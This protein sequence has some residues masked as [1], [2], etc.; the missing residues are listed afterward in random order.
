MVKSSVGFDS[1]LNN[2]PENILKLKYNDTL[3]ATITGY[4]DVIDK[5][6]YTIAHKYS[7]KGFM[8][9]ELLVSYGV[10]RFNEEVNS[11]GLKKKVEIFD[12]IQRHIQIPPSKKNK[13]EIIHENCSVC[14]KKISLSEK[15]IGVVAYTNSLLD[16]GIS[17]LLML[18]I[19]I[20]LNESEYVSKE[21]GWF[22]K[23]FNLEKESINGKNKDILKII[24]EKN[25]LMISKIRIYIK[26][27][28]T[29]YQSYMFSSVYGGK[30]INEELVKTI[31]DDEK[32]ELKK[33]V[34]LKKDIK[35]L[36]LIR[37]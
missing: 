13:L 30:G 7:V 21:F 36:N 29:L 6:I 8:I 14:R 17:D 20:S 31:T 5:I 22:K 28:N 3:R 2:I 1:M 9:E 4:P 35:R 27:I 37:D 16:M 15:T 33:L 12:R 18:C 23:E 24:K 19:I 11:C 10:N 25:L 34:Q 32:I 26:Q